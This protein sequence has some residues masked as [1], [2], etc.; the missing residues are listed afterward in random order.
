MEQ[1]IEVVEV[2]YR[3]YDTFNS[4]DVKRTYKTLGK[5][6]HGI[7]RRYLMESVDAILSRLPAKAYLIDFNN[8]KSVTEDIPATL[9]D[10]CRNLKLALAEIYVRDN[11]LLVKFK[12]FKSTHRALR[13]IFRT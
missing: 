3:D 9:K 7:S 11:D 12:S 2:T 1:V 13:D 8:L 10:L 4:P 5:M 6:F